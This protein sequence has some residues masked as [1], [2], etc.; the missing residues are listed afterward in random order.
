MTL[1]S[2]NELEGQI[3]EWRAYMRRRRELHQADTEEL[4]DHLRS[5]DHRADR[6]GPAGRTRRS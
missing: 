2:D 3:A 6:G 5:Q 1:A 4:E